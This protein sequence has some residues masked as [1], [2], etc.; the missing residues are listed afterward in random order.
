MRANIESYVI[1]VVLLRLVISSC[2]GEWIHCTIENPFSKRLCNRIRENP[3]QKG[4]TIA[5]K[6]TLS[7]RLC[8]RTKEIVRSYWGEYFPRR[9]CNRARE[10]PFQED[11]ERVQ[12]P[13]L[14]ICM[15]KVHVRKTIILF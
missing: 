12:K 10:K 4:C 9:L 1:L 2:H 8:N 11:C 6:R 13:P 15:K 3:F 7:R 5:L 14:K